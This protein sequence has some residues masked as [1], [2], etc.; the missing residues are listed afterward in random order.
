[1][2]TASLNEEDSRHGQGG[3]GTR[4]MHGP[5]PGRG[6]AHPSC[7]RWSTGVGEATG[8]PAATSR[9]GEGSVQ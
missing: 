4:E 9:N 8:M 5:G 2:E 3:P 1:M 6:R 7:Q